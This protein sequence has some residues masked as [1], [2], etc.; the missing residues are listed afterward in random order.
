MSVTKARTAGTLVALGVIL[1]LMLVLGWHSVSAPFPKLGGN[2]TAVQCQTVQKKKRVFRR[3]I[4]VSVYN[5]TKRKGLADTTMNGLEKRDFRPGTVGNAPVGSVSYV[6]VRS[7]VKDDPAALLVSRQFKPV[8]KVM[9]SE[10]ELGPGI[11]VVLG[12]KFKKLHVPSPKSLKLA[13]PKNTCLDGAS[14]K[15]GS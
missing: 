5:A 4:T 15:A 6:E 13:K 8:A 12:K 1:V 9:L 3:E 2:D 10:D 14:P 11:D 7:T